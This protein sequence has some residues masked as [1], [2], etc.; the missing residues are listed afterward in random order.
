MFQ[1][2]ADAAMKN[3][4][5]LTYAGMASLSN[6]VHAT[7]GERRGSAAEFM[8][9]RSE[10]PVSERTK[11]SYMEGTRASNTKIPDKYLK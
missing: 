8:S 5:K 2:L 7:D 1:R 3:G 11:A 6:S 9:S 10:H 4:K